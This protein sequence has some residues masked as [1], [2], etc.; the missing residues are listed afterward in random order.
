MSSPASV[1]SGQPAATPDAS[2]PGVPF[3]RLLRVELRKVYDTR[4]G[5]WLLVA[6][7]VLTAAIITIF[8]FAEGNVADLTH[9]TFYFVTATPQGFLLPVLAILAV[10][11]EWSQRTGLVT[12]TLEPSRMRVIFAKLAAVCLYGLLAVA[13]ALALAALGNVLGA[14]LRDGAGD[15]D[16]TWAFL[17][18][19]T[20]LQLSGLVQGFAFGLVFMNTAAAIVL[21]F[22]LPTIWSILFG[23]VD[24]LADIAPWVDLNTATGPIFEG[25][26]TGEDWAHIA[27]ASTIWVLLPLVLGLWRLTRS[28]VKSA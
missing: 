5:F 15:W 19:S 12:F 10:T 26:L 3:S 13:L 21:Y 22:I 4:A 20:F 2:I 9:R 11:A 17:R 16:I 27:V 24:W 14:S 28:E 8:L 1:A 7:A 23:L 25:D 6:I 18:D